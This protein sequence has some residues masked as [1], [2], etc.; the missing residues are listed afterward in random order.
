[1]IN[2]KHNKF[3]LGVDEAGRGPFFGPVYAAV[4]VWGDAPDNDLIKDS[5][6]I[7]KKKE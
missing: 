7:S 1:M 3:E 6:K 4:V 5:K 2:Y